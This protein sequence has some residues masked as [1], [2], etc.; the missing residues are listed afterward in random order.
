MIAVQEVRHFDQHRGSVVLNNNAGH[1][2]EVQIDYLTN[3][4]PVTQA[5]LSS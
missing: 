4:S 5:T 2:V 3:H 1:M